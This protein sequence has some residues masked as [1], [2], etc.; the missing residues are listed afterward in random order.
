MADED[1][2]ANLPS[3]RFEAALTS[4]ENELLYLRA[5]SHALTLSTCAQAAFLVAVLNDARQKIIEKRSPTKKKSKLLQEAPKR[6]PLLVG[7]IGC[8]RLG[9]QLTNTLL[10][11]SDV[12]PEEIFISTRRPET[13]SALQSR[14][15]HCGFDNV[16]VASAVHILFIACLPSQFST[17]AKEIKGH[18]SCPVYVLTGAIPL[19]RICQILEYDQI[20]KPEFSW[21]PKDK[22][23][24]ANQKWNCQQE[25]LE[26][27]SD[28]GYCEMTC[29]LNTEMKENSLVDTNPRLAE[30]FLFVFINMCSLK[31]LSR[32]EVITMCNTVFLGFGP[33]DDMTEAL[34]EQDIVNDLEA[35]AIK[36]NRIEADDVERFP[37]LDLALVY[38]EQSHLGQRLTHPDGTLRKMFV[39]RYKSVFDKFQYWKGMPTH[40]E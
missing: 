3:L 35:Y 36:T 33:I 40:T 26:I 24:G 39:K 14:G 38:E 6:D 2:S 10:K 15:V 18:L 28:P 16:K 17:V 31:Y 11:Y 4:Q 32:S 9:K 7:I 29:P 27:L 20:I 5:R 8:G 37:L 13:L 23:N 12:H 25:L 21:K 30:L 34:T 19:A 22:D 1:I